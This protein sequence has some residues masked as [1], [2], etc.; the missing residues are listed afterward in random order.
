ML[1]RGEIQAYA[2][3]RQ[4]L[5]Q[6]V[7][8]DA[9]FRVQDDNYFA[10]QQAIAVP[11]SNSASRQVVR[12]GRCPTPLS[13]WPLSWPLTGFSKGYVDG[14]AQPTLPAQ[15]PEQLPILTHSARRPFD[16]ATLEMGHVDSEQ[17]ADCWVV[18]CP[19]L[20]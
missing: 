2:T 5:L 8:A 18:L 7:A 1:E 19:V 17:R 4:R 13:V 20:L 3:N 6:I 16:L 14:E 15:S 11:K 9:R 10:V 12:K